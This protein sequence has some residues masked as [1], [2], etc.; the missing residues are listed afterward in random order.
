MSNILVAE[1]NALNRR[2][3]ERVLG[4]LGH[5][6]TV[7]EDGHAALARLEVEHFDLVLMDVH[8]PRLGGLE[9][10]AL[11]RARE[12]RSA[13]H[14]PVIAL[15]AQV[16]DGAAER[17][18][19]AGMDG[20]LT[21]PFDVDELERAISDAQKAAPAAALPSDD[22]APYCHSVLEQKIGRDPAFLSELTGMF[23]ARAALIIAQIRYA[24]DARQPDRMRDAAH[25]LKGMLLNLAASYD[26]AAACL[27]R[28]LEQ[29][30]R[31]ISAIRAR[32]RSYA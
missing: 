11:L 27:A 16:A 15:T 20:Y 4:D 12:R 3:I 28:L 19:R 21:K 25:E 31:L 8:M 9:A 6:V 7:V 26:T 2:L 17:C 32:A 18:L 23:E 22:G 24:I 29:I 10:V 13:G 14:V 30:P 5:R 1:D